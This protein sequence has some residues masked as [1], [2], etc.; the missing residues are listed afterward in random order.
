MQKKI[1]LKSERHTLFVYLRKFAMYGILVSHH[2]YTR[3]PGL[4]V[5]NNVNFTEKTTN[6]VRTVAIPNWYQSCTTRVLPVQSTFLVK[7]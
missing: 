5:F 4:A 2:N 1:I 7:Y 6:C 3:K